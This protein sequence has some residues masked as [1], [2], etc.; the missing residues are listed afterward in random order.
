MLDC[1]PAARCDMPPEAI[2][3]TLQCASGD[4][5]LGR[6][7]LQVLNSVVMPIPID[8]VDVLALLQ[9]S[10]QVTRHYQAMLQNLADLAS[11]VAANAEGHAKERIVWPDAD[12]LVGADSVASA[13][14]G[15]LWPS[16]FPSAGIA[17]DGRLHPL[18]V[19]LAD[20]LAVAALV[21]DTEDAEG[22]AGPTPV[23]SRNQMALCHCPVNRHDPIIHRQSPESK[24]G[25]PDAMR[26]L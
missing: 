17:H 24:E 7:Q 22:L 6:H 23:L 9:G 8:V 15:M 16:H 5:R 4:V 12:D 13:P 2:D 21:A 14:M 10:A 1:M 11:P 19:A 18:G 25:G 26:A 3:L 20:E